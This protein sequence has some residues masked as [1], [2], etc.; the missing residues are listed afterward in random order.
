MLGELVAEGQGKRT[1]RRVLSADPLKVEVSFEESLTILG[2]QAQDIG[3][4]WAT[5]R[6]DGTLYGEG[7]G[8]IMTA[9][10]DLITWVGSGT[11]KMGAGGA[12]SYRGALHTSTTAAKFARLN[13]VALVFEFEVDA[14]G[15]TKSKDWEWK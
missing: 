13:S 10:G 14:A 5:P 11:G 9:E 15:N 12:V 2:V 1:G 3:T 8:V 6:A 7:Q 4:Y